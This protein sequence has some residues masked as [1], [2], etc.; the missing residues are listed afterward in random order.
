MDNSAN[1]TGPEQ[2]A[3]REGA[4]EAATFVEAAL[5][6]LS[7]ALK[8]VNFYPKGHPTLQVCMDKAYQSL[9]SALGGEE[10]L[11][12]AISRKGFQL[13]SEPVAPAN[14]VLSG[15]ATEFFRRQLN[16][17]FF[18]KGMTEHELM[19]F[20]RVIA[21]EEDLFRGKGKAEEY[22]TDS[23]VTHI[24]ANEIKL[25]QARG[26]PRREEKPPDA[27]Q[28]DDRIA[29]LIE[30]LKSETDPKKYLA[31]AREG[32]IVANRFTDEDKPDQAFAMMRLFWEAFSLEPLR[33]PMIV[34]AAKSAF[35]ELS[36]PSMIEH[37][38]RQLT[39]LDGDRKDEV[40]KV[41][42]SM[43]ALLHEAILAKLATN[44]ALYSHRALIQVL[45]ADTNSTRPLTEAR[46]NDERWWVARKMAFLLGEMGASESVPMLIKAASSSHLRVRKEALKA[47]AKISSP[48]AVQKLLDVIDSKGS[49]EIRLHCIRLIG[50]AKE[51]S[52]ISTLMKIL[53]NRGKL[54]EDIELLEEVVRAL[55]RIGSPQA[56]PIL[57]ELLLKRSVFA[58]AKS[59]NLGVE[60]AEALGVIRGNEAEA[61]LR[62]GAESN[63]QEIR[64]ACLKALK[65][66]QQRPE[67]LAKETD[68][69]E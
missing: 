62:K 60:A 28:I 51:H 21:M 35:K 4:N 48:D 37:I 10:Q 17:I 56:V 33:A 46:I 8:A 2:G 57:S 32:C 61:V 22:L 3:P 44:E 24:W 9:T 66:Q 67:Q 23:G 55:G 16:K 12:L 18:L 7:R 13:G 68:Q 36:S 53:K 34:E 29:K 64:L 42:E 50:S 41:A 69:G 27:T 52:A 30:A 11:G 45:L 49:H 39:L 38:L 25:G 65:A 40:L 26:V 20:L 58:R 43:G 19:D 63:Q 14:T 6:E 5:I 47:L 31:L 1:G 54:L 15:L 59:I